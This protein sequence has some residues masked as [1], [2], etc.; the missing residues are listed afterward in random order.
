[1]LQKRLAHNLVKLRKSQ[2]L[3]QEAAAEL[4]DLSPRFWGKLEQCRANA[5]IATLEKISHGL[6]ISVEELLQERLAEGKNH[7]Q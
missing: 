5:T 4:C 1:M 3:S 2:N 6:Q 7:L